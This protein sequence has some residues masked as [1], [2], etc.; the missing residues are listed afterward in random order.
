MRPRIFSPLTL[1]DCN[2]SSSAWPPRGHS[3]PWKPH[4]SRFFTPSSPKRVCPHHFRDHLQAS[5]DQQR[6][7]CTCCYSQEHHLL[8]ES[9]GTGGGKGQPSTSGV[10]ISL[11]C[12]CQ[13]PI[14]VLPPRSWDTL[15]S[16]AS[17]DLQRVLSHPCI[18]WPGSLRQYGCVQQNRKFSP[19]SGLSIFQ[20]P[21]ML[22]P[23]SPLKRSPGN[24]TYELRRAGCPP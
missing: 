2:K 24:R 14:Q 8:P 7:S 5:L 6:G 15:P 4:S 9:R 21:R 10:A 22:E 11:R 13:T 16:G 1:P 20:S 19:G 23:G 17:S 18:S 12:S 3:H